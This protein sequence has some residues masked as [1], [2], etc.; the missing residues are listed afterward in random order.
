[1]TCQLAI[2][3][4]LN[5]RSVDFSFI[6]TVC[7]CALT[8]LLELAQNHVLVD[9][10][11]PRQGASQGNMNVFSQNGSSNGWRFS[12]CDNIELIGYLK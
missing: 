2:F 11:K 7:R 9:L 4:L 1:M 8:F 6:G 12:L 10:K 3:S 5:H